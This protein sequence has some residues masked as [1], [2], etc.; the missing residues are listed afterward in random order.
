M[1]NEVAFVLGIDPSGSFHEGKGTTGM[2]VLKRSSKKV[3]STKRVM[4]I[5]AVDYASAPA[6]WHAHLQAIKAA[7]DM[8]PG[9]VVSLEDYIL[10]ESKAMA[11]SNSKLE[12][13]RLIGAIQVFCWF[14]NI[15][16]YI[17]PAV[18]AKSRWRNE[19]LVRKGVLREENGLYYYDKNSKPVS[20]HCLDALRHAMHCMLFEL[21][22]GGKRK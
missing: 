7:V 4:E 10:Y 16:L 14:N 22:K 12:T 13:S 8:Y 11:Q 21:P 2:W 9:I 18:I 17:R 5:K 15:P 6:Y 3:L 20:R 1:S 19:T